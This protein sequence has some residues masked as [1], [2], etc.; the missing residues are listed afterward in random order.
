M[1]HEKHQH[2]AIGIAGSQCNPHVSVWGH[3]C[4]YVELLAESL[5]WSRIEH[6]SPLPAPL[7]KVCLW[8]PTLINIDDSLCS[9]IHLQ[10]LLRVQTAEHLVSLWIALERNALYFSVREWELLFQH[11]LDCI[12]GH[13]ES[14]WWFNKAL[15]VLYRPNR[16]LLVEHLL[17]SA[18]YCSLITRPV[19]FPLPALYDGWLRALECRGKLGYYG[20]S[21]VEDFTDLLMCSYFGSSHLH[22]LDANFS[23]D[24]WQTKSLSFHASKVVL[25]ALQQVLANMLLL[26]GSI[27]SSQPWHLLPG[28]VITICATNFVLFCQEFSFGFKFLPDLCCNYCVASKLIFD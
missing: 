25:L 10:H 18:G 2:A 16:V 19:Q 17:Y 14:K 4:D 27:T 12:C 22:Y 23:T 1:R 5:V 20:G 21:N 24:L 28:I 15:N 3:C 11:F 13:R 26:D 8:Q 7:V 9:L 6:P